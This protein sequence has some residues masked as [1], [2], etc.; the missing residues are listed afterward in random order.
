[1]KGLQNGSRAVLAM[2]CVIVLGLIGPE[3]ASAVTHSGPLDK[4]EVRGYAQAFGVSGTIAE[5]HL[6][7]QRE[8]SALPEELK[9]AMGS[10]YAGLWFDNEAGRFVVPVPG[11]GG[12]AAAVQTLASTRLSASAYQTEEVSTTWLALERAQKDL[13]AALSLQAVRGEVETAIDPRTNAVVL[14]LGEGVD[15]SAEA[16]MKELAARQ[17]VKVEVR[18][19]PVQRFRVETTSCKTTSPRA[20]DAP[21]RGGVDLGS[22]SVEHRGTESV[23]YRATGICSAGFKATGNLYGNRFILTAGHCQALRPGVSGW[24]SETAN[25][26]EHNIGPMEEFTFGPTGD[27]AKIKANGSWWDNSPW[28]SEVAHYWEDQEYPIYY[29]AWS[30]PGE[31]VCLSGAKSGTTCGNVLQTHLEGLHV[32]E[33]GGVYL[34]PE[35]EVIGVCT[36]KGDSGG[37]IFSF[38]ANTA[39][40]LLSAGEG[41]PGEGANCRAFYTEITEATTA[42]GVSV[43]ARIGGPPLAATVGVSGVTGTQA[44][45]NGTVYPNA[46]PTKY[47]FEY[48]PTTSYGH[49]VPSPAGEAGHGTGGLAVSAVLTG[50]E[51]VSVYH[52]RLVAVSVAGTSYGADV[53]FESGPGSPLVTTEG[54]VEREL[55]GALLL[56]SVNPRHADTNYWFEIGQTTAYGT[57]VPVPAAHAGAGKT[58]VAVSQRCTGLRPEVTYHYRLVASNSVGTTYGGDHMFTTLARTPTYRTFF[59]SSGSGNGQL[60]AP[61]EA[62]VD[63]AGDIWVADSANNRVE[64]FSRTG[65][66]M[67]RFGIKG[68]APGQLLEPQGVAVGPDGDLWIADTGNGRIEKFTPGGEYLA[69]MGEGEEGTLVWKQDPISRPVGIAVDGEGHIWVADPGD[70]RVERMNEANDTFHGHLGGSFERLGLPLIEPEKEFVNPTG[71]AVGP[72][73]AIWVVDATRNWLVEIQKEKLI[74]GVWNYATRLRGQG[75]GS[76]EGQMNEPYAVAVKPLGNLMVAERGNNRVQELSPRGEYLTAFGT[77]GSGS[78]QMTGPQGVA[79]Q[80][81]GGALYVIDSGDNRVERWGQPVPPETAT[82]AASPIKPTTA[83]LHATV[84]PGSEATTYQF[85]YGPTASYGSKAPATPASA[86]SGSDPVEMSVAISGLKAESGYHFRIVASNAEGTV[87]GQDHT[88]STPGPPYDLAFGATGAGN[89]QFAEP[90]GVAVEAGGN[91]WVVDKGNN[92]LEKF[93]PNGEYLAQFGSKG[94]GNGQFLEPR[95]VAISP[96]GNLWVTD[97][98]NGRLEEFTSAGAFIRQVGIKEGGGLLGG[99]DHLGQPFGVAIGS[100]HH[101]WVTDP[102]ECAVE[103]FRETPESGEKYFVA[104]KSNFIS[105]SGTENG[106]FKYPAGVTAD[107]EGHAWIVDSTLNR[108]TRL[109][110]V[111]EGVLEPHFAF[112]VQAVFGS[113]GTG[114]GQFSGP[115]GIALKASAARLFVADRGNSRV[116]MLGTA[117][118]FQ[119]SFGSQGT[120]AEQFVAPTGVAVAPGGAE[121]VTDPGANRVEKWG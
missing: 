109:A 60:S 3:V 90:G 48:G 23:E 66:F 73:G 82:G 4:L 104:R 71:I 51:P 8:G 20:C 121:Y 42:M 59:A 15:S 11:A 1:M 44:T 7:R 108:I 107:G 78:G 110:L 53:E 98:G 112:S 38:S 13:T 27:W 19:Y 17:P 6:L 106:A 32:G 75:T 84:N 119:G 55:H 61:G 69:E 70:H 58:P 116:Q 12:A 103:V 50:L 86:G 76:G 16:E 105:C 41:E 74:E 54:V 47:Y 100:E 21:L 91:V 92:R 113:A 25:T 89:G 80:T 9:Q 96:E 65:K 57:S 117:G 120:G 39:L 62:A 35:T 40:G 34:P 114:N 64:E 94:S 5:S 97:A 67:T 72:E 81:T 37:P 85:E 24:F 28:P 33:G 101:V 63:G 45:A 102:G 14:W 77:K 99:T 118:E 68:S 93:T 31:Y 83:T 26:S 29:E 46:V 49:V 95:D 22:I 52:M 10:R 111:K 30:Y 87:Y 2:S 18:Q 43:G 79:L 88:F 56:G 36:T 115:V